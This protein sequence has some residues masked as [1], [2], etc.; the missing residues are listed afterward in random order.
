VI[1]FQLAGFIFGLQ[2]VLWLSERGRAAFQLVYMAKLEASGSLLR[3][4]EPGCGASTRQHDVKGSHRAE[5]EMMETQVN[6]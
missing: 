2:R 1:T 3:L 4:G 6:A 5:T